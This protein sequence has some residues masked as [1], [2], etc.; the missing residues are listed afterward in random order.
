[1]LAYALAYPEVV[2][3]ANRRIRESRRAGSARSSTTLEC[4]ALF[5]LSVWDINGT[6]K[7]FPRGSASCARSPGRRPARL[8]VHRRLPQAN[9]YP[10]IEVPILATERHGRPLDHEPRLGAADV[11]GRLVDVAGES[12]TVSGDRRRRALARARRRVA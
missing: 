9:D 4:R 10:M 3:K 8:R 6:P 11:R 7:I 12:A 2:L 1:M 5:D